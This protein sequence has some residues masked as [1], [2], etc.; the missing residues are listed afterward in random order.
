[1]PRSGTPRAC[2]CA[3]AIRGGWPALFRMSGAARRLAEA[4]G[5]VSLCSRVARGV[6]EIGGGCELDQLTVTSFG[7]H[8]HERGEIGDARRLLHVVGHDHDRVLACQL[9]YQVFD[10]QGGDGIES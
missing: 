7:I 8:E 6:E 5:D 3:R 2:P 10:L 9:H 4:P 1:M